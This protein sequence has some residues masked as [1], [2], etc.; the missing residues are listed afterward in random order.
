LLSELEKLNES[1]S[2]GPKR[3]VL[4]I[5]I[6][7]GDVSLDSGP[8]GVEIHGDPIH[9]A[10]RIEDLRDEELTL[11]WLDLLESAGSRTLISHELRE[12]IKQTAPELMEALRGVAAG[13]VQ[14]RGYST[15]EPVY[16]IHPEHV[17]AALFSAP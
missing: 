6:H 9:K 5:G 11:L 13:M 2:P 16:L 14:L 12:Q 1:I 4:R 15:E 17:P 3:I 8:D 10:R 7:G